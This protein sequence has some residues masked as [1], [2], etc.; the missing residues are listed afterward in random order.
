[1]LM[2]QIMGAS[3]TARSMCGER[4]KRRT[5]EGH[6]DEEGV[7]YLDRMTVTWEIADCAILPVSS[8]YGRFLLFLFTSAE[9]R[10]FLYIRSLFRR[11][12]EG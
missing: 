9:Q 5:S 1:M 10:I 4:R 2:E 12:V 7:E 11:S 8:R 3:Y 6:G